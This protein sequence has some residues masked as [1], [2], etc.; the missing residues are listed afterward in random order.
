MATDQIKLTAAQIKVL[1]HIAARPGTMP[2]GAGIGAARNV[3]IRLGLV[4][5]RWTV[6][7]K[8]RKALAD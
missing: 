8:G 6:T 3:R 4:D 5:N 2:A 1:R 7:E